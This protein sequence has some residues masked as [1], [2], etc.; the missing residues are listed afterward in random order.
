M[1]ESEIL[2][3]LGREA[4]LRTGETTSA[5]TLIYL[6]RSPSMEAPTNVRCCVELSQ[7]QHERLTALLG[8]SEEA[9]WSSFRI[10]AL[11]RFAPHAP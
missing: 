6:S 11:R 4:G 5:R 9:A 2:P 7:G 3:L 1:D 8:G 10:G